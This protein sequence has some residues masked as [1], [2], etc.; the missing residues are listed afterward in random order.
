[1]VYSSVVIEPVRDSTYAIYRKSGF[2][3]MQKWRVEGLR[4][5]NIVF[6][7]HELV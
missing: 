4:N 5:K 3:A 7:I 6:I 1:M 2:T